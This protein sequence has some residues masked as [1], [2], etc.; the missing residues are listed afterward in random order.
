MLSPDCHEIISC[1]H[2][3]RS[4]PAS[5]GQPPT[6]HPIPNMRTEGQLRESIQRYQECFWDKKS[7]DRP[8]VGVYDERIF[9]PI[10]FLRRPFPRPTVSPEDVTSDLAMPEYEYSFAKRAVS[11]DDYMAFSAPWRGV[12]WL[13]ASCG[14]TVRYAKGSLAPAHFVESAEDL[15]DLPIPAP[16]GWLDCLRRET[17]RLESQAPPDCWISPTILRG[18]S[19]V[20]AAMREMRAFFVDLHDHPEALAT[21][22]ARLNQLLIKALD[23]HYS[24]VRP[25]LGGFGH[26]FGYWAP[27]RTIVIQEDVMG[28]CSPDMY[29][30]I[31]MPNNAEVVRHMGDY[32]LFH[33]HTT[34]YKHYKHV[35]DIPGIAGLEIGME[36]IGPTIVDL[37]P[38]FREILERSRLIL[39][40][41][42][43]FESLPQ[44]LRKLP[45]EGLCVAIADRY[46]RNDQEFFALTKAIWQC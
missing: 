33:L 2:T 29:R 15:A 38:V 8:P 44:V 22:A 20:L 46:I 34:G 26:I 40:V 35:L 32:V 45:V 11:C 5:G 25:K 43:G 21:A 14:C 36:S 9:L 7:A 39:H 42:S 10:N 13:E 4:R 31:F 1:I 24:I 37:V 41:G 23:L 27:G 19:D 30:D 6:Q 18:P 28:M 12:P 16:N 17:E 3:Y